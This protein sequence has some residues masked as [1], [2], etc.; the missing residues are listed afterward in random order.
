MLQNKYKRVNGKFVV[1]PE[2]NSVKCNPGKKRKDIREPFLEE[3]AYIYGLFSPI[4]NKYFYVGQ[5]TDPEKR[6]YQHKLNK[7]ANVNKK[8]HIS[9]LKKRKLCFRMD[10]LACVS[11][12]LSDKWETAYIKYLRKMGHPLTN[13]EESSE[14]EVKDTVSNEDIE[15]YLLLDDEPVDKETMKYIN[16]LNNL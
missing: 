4:L 9:L 10:L 5:T 14:I 7:E 12:K 3:K 1:V 6:A 16:F 8:Y 2:E 15:T 13:R 11:I